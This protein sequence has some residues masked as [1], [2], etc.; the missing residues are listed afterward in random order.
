MTSNYLINGVDLGDILMELTSV[1]IPG[2]PMPQLLNYYNSDNNM[3]ALAYPLTTP[4]TPYTY[5][6]C[7]TSPTNYLI[8]GTDLS[9]TY[10]PKYDIITNGVPSFT[11][12]YNINPKCT[13]IYFVLIGNGGGGGYGNGV[14]N[15][16]AGGGGGGCWGYF[17]MPTA[18]Y[19]NIKLNYYYNQ[20]ENPVTLGSPLPSSFPKSYITITGDAIGGG[21]PLLAQAYAYAGTDGF[22]GGGGSGEPGGF[23]LTSGNITCNYTN[24]VGGSG[25]GPANYTTVGGSGYNRYCVNQIP[26]ISSVSYPYSPEVISNLGNGGS[27]SNNQGQGRGPGAQGIIQLWFVY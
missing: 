27:G 23:I 24:E 3:Y 13:R 9:E 18:N 10:C 2:K 8:N 17:V 22:V 4:P 15:G 20:Q 6:D 7:K 14:S 5:Y 12:M 11:G 16:G 21:T 19:E 26:S 25:G 1:P